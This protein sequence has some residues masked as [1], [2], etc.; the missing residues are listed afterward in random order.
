ME[1]KQFFKKNNNRANFFLQKVKIKKS[2][3]E[4]NVYLKNNELICRGYIS[5]ITNE[6][7]YKLLL[8]YKINSVPKV[9]IKGNNDID[10][11]KKH[12][13]KDGSLCLYYPQEWR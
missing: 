4:M 3:P 9:W 6:Q 10:K 8:K 5:P 2:F 7:K 11:C 1:Y 13:Y 12:I